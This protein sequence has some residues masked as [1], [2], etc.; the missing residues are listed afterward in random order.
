[1]QPQGQA[2]YC[3]IHHVPMRW[4]EG[5]SKMGKNYAFWTCGQ[6]NPDNSWCNFKPQMPAPQP[7]PYQVPSQP[8]TPVTAPNLAPQ[9]T[10]T[11]EQEQISRSVAL[12]AAIDFYSGKTTTQEAV[13]DT[14]GRFLNF[15]TGKVTAPAPAPVPVQIPAPQPIVQTY[16]V[17]NDNAP[18][19]EEPPF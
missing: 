18:L 14:A 11:T 17:A 19:P 8:Q 7:E 5:V 6:K 12:K 16:V 4:K 10:L 9:R 2:P 3:A 15:L 1:M 13:I